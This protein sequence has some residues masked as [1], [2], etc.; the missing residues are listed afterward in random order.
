MGQGL[1]CKVKTMDSSAG[2]LGL[3]PGFW[4][5]AAQLPITYFIGSLRE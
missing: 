2:L 4:I 3:A 1:A 5:L